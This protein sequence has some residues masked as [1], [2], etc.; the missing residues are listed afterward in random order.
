MH[1]FDLKPDQGTVRE[2]FFYNQIRIFHNPVKSETADFLVDKKWTI[3]VG[4]RNKKGKQIEN[5]QNAFRALDGIE[6]GYG[7]VIPLWIFGFLY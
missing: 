6:T 5:Q 4:G 1:C 7:N 3:E 2:T